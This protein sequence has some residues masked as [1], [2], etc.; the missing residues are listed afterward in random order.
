MAAK[1]PF[2]DADAQR[3][4]G[5]IADP[6]RGS[7]QSPD[8]SGRRAG[9]CARRPGNGGGPGRHRAV[10]RGEFCRRSEGTAQ[11]AVGRRPQLFGRRP[12]GRLDHQSCP[13]SPRSKMRSASRSIRC[14]FAP[15]CMSRGWPAWHEFEL[16]DQTL[17]IGDVRLK[18]V[19]RIVRCAAVNVDP[20]TCC[21][22]PRYPPHADAPVRP[23]RL[24]RLCRGHRRRR[25]WPSA[26]RSQRKRRSCCK[27]APGSLPV[28]ASAAKQS[29]LRYTGL[30]RRLRSSQ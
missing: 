20:G 17:A 26:M 3:A 24:R 5:G 30:L 28:I 1:I 18:V 13:A 21:A 9:G 19:K 11:G 12:K 27:A 7:H 23:R 6:F 16:L 22:R 15:I 4:P 25:H 10:L 29:M 8:H 2:P 14:D